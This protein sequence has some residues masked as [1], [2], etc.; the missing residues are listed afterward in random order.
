LSHEVSLQ[1]VNGFPAIA[2]TGLD[3]F[4][5]FV[6]AENADGG[7]WSAPVTVEGTI[8]SS[9]VWLA[10]IGGVPAIAFA[11]DT[12]YGVVYAQANDANGTA[13]GA[14]VVVDE[15][16]AGADFSMVEVNGYPGIAYYTYTPALKYAYYVP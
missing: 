4:V 8:I 15:G 2:Y 7:I 13:W 1:V 14:P 9:Y 3:S 6:R 16:A 5:R 10:V 12:N 11:D